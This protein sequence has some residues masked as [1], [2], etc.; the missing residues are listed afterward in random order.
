MYAPHTVTV[1]NVIQEVDVTTFRETERT[2]ITILR[3]VFLDAA[4]ASNVR[5][6][7]I[8]G[9]DAANLFIPLDVAAVGTNG[10]AKSF[11]SPH[12]FVAARDRSALW[13]LSTSGDGVE[14]FF[15]KG[16]VSATATVA[17]AMD[18][19]YAVTKV[20]KKDYG[21]SRMMH[22]EVGGK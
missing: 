15:V 13:T 5:V 22:F 20:D 2:Y 4:K 1:Y 16:V 17:R 11:V 8:E 7:G 6:S 21:S 10:G 14:T 18:D 19:S 9:A 3:G 12:E